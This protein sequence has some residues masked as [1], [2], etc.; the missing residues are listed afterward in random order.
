[1]DKH[2][3][4]FLIRL[5]RG[6]RPHLGAYEPVVQKVI[7]KMQEMLPVIQEQQRE[8][9]KLVDSLL[10]RYQPPQRRT[11]IRRSRKLQTWAVA[12]E[13]CRRSREVVFTEPK[14]AAH[15]GQLA[16]ECALRVE[17]GTPAVGDLRA[18]CC[19]TIANAYRVLGWF[20]E[21]SAHFESAYQHLSQEGV[22]DIYTQADVFSLHA[23]LLKDQQHYAEA[24]TVLAQAIRV[25]GQE[26]DERRLARCLIQKACVLGIQGD[27]MAAIRVYYDA[28]QV[29]DDHRDPWLTLVATQNLA[30]LYCDL[31][32]YKLARSALRTL[33]DEVLREA[34][35][36]SRESNRL[37]LVW[38]R[39]RIAAGFGQRAQ[40]LKMLDEVERGFLALPDPINAG[41]AALDAAKLHHK[42]RHHAQVTETLRRVHAALQHHDFPRPLREMAAMLVEAA[43]ERRLIQHNLEQTM[44][45]LQR[46]RA[47]RPC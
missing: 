6:V 32:N 14:E 39:A 23:S 30:S 4:A 41:L 40:A 38:T 25:L 24:L 27:R 12:E 9:G 44:R 36:P 47:R 19:A 42:A 37:H 20:Q 11:G 5:P 21:A 33:S 16:L 10:A 22:G 8:A 43:E 45:R 29:I 31:G 18:F 15:L 3:R 13:L 2:L 34:L 28:L 7:Q 35:G 17:A 26:G 1:M 46:L